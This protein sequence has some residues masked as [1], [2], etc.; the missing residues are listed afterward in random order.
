MRHTHLAVDRV[1][2][3]V[4]EPRNVEGHGLQQQHDVAV[5]FNGELQRGELLA[6]SKAQVASCRGAQNFRLDLRRPQMASPCR[7]ARE[8][9]APSACCSGP[10]RS[11]VSAKQVG[12]V[13]QRS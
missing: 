9:P 8:L 11:G 2:A 5:S 13:E 10:T 1:E 7:A 6:I 3:P 4:K 12:N